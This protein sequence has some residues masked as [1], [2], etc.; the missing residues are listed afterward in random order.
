MKKIVLLLLSITLVACNGGGSSDSSGSS[1]GG[2]TP[3]GPT[4]DPTPIPSPTPDPAPSGLLLNGK[5]VISG[6]FGAITNKSLS[7]TSLRNLLLQADNS[8]KQMPLGTPQLTSYVFAKNRFVAVGSSNYYDHSYYGL[9]SDDGINWY[10][11]NNFTHTTPSPLDIY[12]DSQNQ[13]YLLP[14]QQS[15]DGVTWTTFNNQGRVPMSYGNSRYL[16]ISIYGTYYSLDSATW[17]QA[18]DNA[19]TFSD[20]GQIG[21]SFNGQKF[22]A[23]NNAITYYKSQYGI[24]ADGNNWTAQNY[25][26]QINNSS[27]TIKNL[28]NSYFCYFNLGDI[29]NASVASSSNGINWNSSVPLNLNGESQLNQTAVTYV[30]Y[31]YYAYCGDK[32]SIQQVESGGYRLCSSNNGI[33]WNYFGHTPYP[34][35]GNDYTSYGL[36]GDQTLTYQYGKYFLFGKFGKVWYSTDNMQ[37]WT[38]TVSG[39]SVTNYNTFQNSTGLSFVLGTT[40]SDYPKV[41]L[42][43]AYSTDNAASFKMAKVPNIAQAPR[44]IATSG[45]DYVVVGNAGTLLHSTDG[46]NWTSINVSNITTSDL[47]NVQYLNGK[48]YVTGDLGY[49]LTS[50]NG[51]NWSYSQASGNPR[52]MDII[53]NNNKFFVVG[54]GGY[55]AY[56]LNGTNWIKATTSTSNQINSV[57]FGNSVYVAVGNSG[58]ILNSQDGVTWSSVSAAA[59][60]NS[61]GIAIPLSS[62][63]NS[64]IYDTQDGFVAVGEHGLVIKSADGKNWLIDS[65]STYDYSSI[66]PLD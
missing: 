31:K 34:V 13:K 23:S 28:N 39:I 3:P 19:Y 2:N 60:K 11:S 35:T 26:I 25:P 4:P 12:Y 14:N 66:T 47:T 58:T 54:Y 65:P 22:L 17:L 33:D 8:W 61:S 15:T 16:T 51:I 64:I 63:I 32:S 48:Y 59:I 10:K 5:Y 37:T 57:V 27:C 46:I 24:S 42:A 52:L 50:S 55:I 6:N 38:Q 43:I 30:N 20:S 45:S 36:S 18:N 56:S 53:Y 21:L 7:N 40:N 44:A 1:G 41:E 49:V 9:F 29:N 62:S